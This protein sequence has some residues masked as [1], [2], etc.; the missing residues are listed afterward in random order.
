[1]NTCIK[2]GNKRNGKDPYC[3]DCRRVMYQATLTAKPTCSKCGL[4]PHGSNSVWCN[5]CR[6][7]YQKGLRKRNPGRWYRGL[8]DFQKK[9]RDARQV[10][11]GMIKLGLMARLPCEICG[12]IKSEGHHH[13]GYEGK[14]ALDVQWLCKKHHV[15]ADI[16]MGL[17][18]GRPRLK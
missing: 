1:M 2:C 6:N 3:S 12:N 16:K 11:Y 10:I 9:K 4:R 18:K 5:P 13:R 7:E 17:N 15:Q 8:N 14:N